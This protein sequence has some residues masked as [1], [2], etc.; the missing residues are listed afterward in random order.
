MGSLRKKKMTVKARK[1]KKERLNNV[2]KKLNKKL[3]KKVK[4][5]ILKLR[6]IASENEDLYEELRRLLLNIARAFATAVEAKDPYSKGH[7]ERV[8]QYALAIARELPPSFKNGMSSDST[9]LL[10]L[11]ALLHDIGKIGIRE[12]ILDKKGSL[13]EKEWEE[14]KKHPQIGAEILEPIQELKEVV[15]DIKHHHERMD[16]KGYPDGLK[17]GEIPL[18]SRIIAVADAFEAMTADR[19]YRRKIS[20]EAAVEELKRCS[21]TQFDKDIIDVCIR[22]YKKG[23]MTKKTK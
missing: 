13:T 17:K 19:P 18:V 20:K 10:R 22:A 5:I 9:M 16:G 1:K 12:G 3:H 21:G 4:E 8:A 15:R 7:T 23:K 14:M 11:T 2:N 6:E